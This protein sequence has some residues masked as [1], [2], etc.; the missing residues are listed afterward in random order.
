MRA[1]A[2]YF[3]PSTHSTRAVTQHN[4]QTA[5]QTYNFGTVKLPSYETSLLSLARLGAD[6]DSSD[7]GLT[8]F[9]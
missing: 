5:A 2:S 6:G 3:A 4:M 8:S 1:A 7:V 9:G